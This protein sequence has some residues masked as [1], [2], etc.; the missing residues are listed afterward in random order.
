M[1]WSRPS[2][3]RKQESDG[4]LPSAPFRSGRARGATGLFARPS[5][6]EAAAAAAE[7]AA[8][9]AIRAHCPGSG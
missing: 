1:I 7:A 5:G 4:A 8:A 3:P 2:A 6:A 9:A